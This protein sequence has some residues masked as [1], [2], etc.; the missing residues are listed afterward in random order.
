M[1]TTRRRDAHTSLTRLLIAAGML[2][3]VVGGCAES[4]PGATTVRGAAPIDTRDDATPGFESPEAALAAV[5]AI[6]GIEA[7]DTLLDM[8][9]PRNQAETY[10]VRWDRSVTRA[11]LDYAAAMSEHFGDAAAPLIDTDLGMTALLDALRGATFVSRTDQKS[12]V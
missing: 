3:V 6:G 8:V 10:L 12:V 11:R 7:R 5:L 4:D 2:V 9:Y 1:I